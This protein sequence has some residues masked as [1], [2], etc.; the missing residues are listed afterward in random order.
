METTPGKRKNQW[1]KRYL[2]AS[3]V[4]LI[5]TTRTTVHETAQ[6]MRAS[7]WSVAEAAG[8]D[9]EVCILTLTNRFTSGEV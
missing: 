9:S 2:G 7:L 4:A 5:C 6:E 8:P 3:Q 1:M